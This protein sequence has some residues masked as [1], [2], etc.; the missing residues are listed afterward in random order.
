MDGSDHL[1]QRESQDLTGSYMDGYD[2]LRE[3]FN[4]DS[5]P[6]DVLES[7]FFINIFK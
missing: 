1:G 2:L 6:S 3:G 5:H 7:L 4:L